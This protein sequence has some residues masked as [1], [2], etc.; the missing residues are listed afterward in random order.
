MRHKLVIEI[1]GKGALPLTEPFEVGS[2]GAEL[3]SHIT[4]VCRRV[5]PFELHPREVESLRTA[6]HSGL[7]WGHTPPPA[8]ALP[9]RGPM[10]SHVRMLTEQPDGDWVPVHDFEL[11]R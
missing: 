6:L 4:L 7:L 8:P 10:V 5:A 11:G 2:L 3:F 9:A 1:P